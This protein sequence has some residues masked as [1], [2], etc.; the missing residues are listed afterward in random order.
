MNFARFLSGFASIP[1]L[2]AA[3]M[4]SVS[5][6]VTSANSSRAAWSAAGLAL[7][8]GCNPVLRCQAPEPTFDEQD[9]TISIHG[10]V[11]DTLTKNPVSGA[12]V[13][14]DRLPPPPPNALLK[15]P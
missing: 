7:V 4:N 11:I 13:Y 8:L 14:L 5:R 2:F 10:V 12:I 6:F 1:A 9:W 15:L 3:P